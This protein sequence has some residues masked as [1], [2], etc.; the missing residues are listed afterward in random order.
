MIRPD[1][2]FFIA[3][4]LV[5]GNNIGQ[6]DTYTFAN[7]DSDHTISVSVKGYDVEE[8]NTTKIKVYPNPAKEKIFVE[9][10]G[11]S[12]VNLYDLLGN[13]LRSM[14]G[15]TNNEMSLSGITKGVYVLMI[16]TKDNRI[17]YQKLIVAN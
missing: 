16:E 10:D 9:G 5:D 14:N 15:E 11:L 4:V 7:V 8:H 6:V 13:C 1:F 3:E 12:L 2:G 17:R